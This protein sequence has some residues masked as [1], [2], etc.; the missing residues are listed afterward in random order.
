MIIK[1]LSASFGRLSN[2]TLKL[3]GGLNIIEAPNESGKSTWCAFIRTMLYGIRTS[4]RDKAGYLSDKTRYRPWSGVPMEGAMDLDVGGSSL[5]LE[6]KSDGKLPMRDFSAVYTGTSTPY[7]G[8]YPDTAGDTLIGVSEAVFERS[9]FISQSGIKVGQTPELEKRIASLVTT[10]DET[11]SYIEADERLRMWLRK[12]R[13]NK[14]GAIPALEEKLNAINKKLSHIESALDEAASMRLEAER[15]KKRQTELREESAAFDR[16]DA[17]QAM[18][19]AMEKHESVKGA[20][21]DIYRELTKNGPAPTDSDLS[22]IRGEAQ[23]LGSLQTMLSI[24][25]THLKDAQDRCTQ[26]K[27]AG[28]TAAFDSPDA[29]LAAQKAAVLEQAVKQSSFKNPRVVLVALLAVIMTLLAIFAEAIA[30]QL[31]AIRAIAAGAVIICTVILIWRGV[32]LSRYKK[33]LSALL[34]RYN[35]RSIE[36]LQELYEEN[37]KASA[38]LMEAESEVRSCEKSVSSASAMVD[39]VFENLRTKLNVLSPNHDIANIHIAN[40]QIANI[41]NELRRIEALFLKLAGAK[42]DIQAAESYLNTMKASEQFGSDQ[43]PGAAAAPVRRKPEI[44]SDLGLVTSRLEDLTNRY[45]MALGEIRAIGDPVILGTEKMSAESELQAQKAQYEALTLAIETLKDANNELQLRFS[46][47]LS[48]TAGRIIQRLTGGRYEK[49]TFDKALDASAKT[50]AETVSHSVLSLSCGTA[51]QIYLALRLAVCGLI[52]PKENPCP[53]ILDD[54]LTNFDDE[55]AYLALDYLKELSQT[56]QILLF[57][58]H[59]RETGY[60]AGSNDVNII[61]L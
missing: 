34:A 35:V 13:F 49:L 59:K 12:R 56:R 55:R 24:E 47:L 30:P 45:N 61:K 15:L 53:L 57:T 19:R 51:D 18:R 4:D 22:A 20:Y 60:F 46:P 23:A 33:E 44:S 21:G 29:P 42:A 3:G 1:R 8:L 36:A 43:N 48:E 37:L 54:A 38:D 7:E 26:I 40:I 5:T 9:A 2:E 58:C 17:Q 27:S 6:R 10:G 31:P 39:T 25:Q 14:S 52:L 11:S 50:A 16:F 28:K 41:E 32:K